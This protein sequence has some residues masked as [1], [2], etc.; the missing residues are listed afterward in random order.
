MEWKLEEA[1]EAADELKKDQLTSFL[2][3]NVTTTW[4][5]L[6]IVQQVC[7]KFRLHARHQSYIL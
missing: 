2:P 6:A 1:L 4:T 3:T 7:T 5:T